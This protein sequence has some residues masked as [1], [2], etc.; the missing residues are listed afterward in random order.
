MGQWD[1]SN[2]RA[3]ALKQDLVANGPEAI[4]ISLFHHLP[5]GF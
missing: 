5:D 2:F 3:H 1:L 4:I